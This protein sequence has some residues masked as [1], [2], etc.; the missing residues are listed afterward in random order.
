MVNI[1]ASRSSCPR[2]NHQCFQYFSEDFYEL[3]LNIL[4]VVKRGQQQMLVEQLG[5]GILAL[6]KEMKPFNREPSILGGST[7][8]G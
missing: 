6:Q 2:F 8:P 4:L 3:P 5:C 7:G 1:L